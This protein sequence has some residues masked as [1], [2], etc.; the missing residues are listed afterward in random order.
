[1]NL[2]EFMSLRAL[3]DK[4]VQLTFRSGESVLA[5]L[6]SITAD[7]DQNQHLVYDNVENPNSSVVNQTA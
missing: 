5:R 3:E 1:M 6:L 7:F 4:R 2:E